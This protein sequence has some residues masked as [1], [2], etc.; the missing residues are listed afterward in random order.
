MRID[1]PD[2][3]RHLRVRLERL[4]S[5]A[6]LALLNLLKPIVVKLGSQDQKEK[7]DTEWETH[8]QEMGEK[9]KSLHRQ[10]LFTNVGLAVC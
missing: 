7:F 10:A 1:F 5:R 3:R 8:D 2:M 4:R 6:A 9:W